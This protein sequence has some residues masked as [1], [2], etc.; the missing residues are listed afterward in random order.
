MKIYVVHGYG[1]DP[2]ES[3]IETYAIVCT[4]REDA[5]KQFNMIIEEQL[6]M[7]KSYTYCGV[8]YVET[9]RKRNGKIHHYHLDMIYDLRNPA[10][11]EAFLWS[12]KV[13][14]G[15]INNDEFHPVI[16]NDDRPELRIITEASV[17][18]REQEIE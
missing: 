14:G 18:I 17:S 7:A 2:S 6:M 11:K 15:N 12:T 13:T 4:S 10:Q 16:D 9:L 1:C 3:N 8:Q 5:E